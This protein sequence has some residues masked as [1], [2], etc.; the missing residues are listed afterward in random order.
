MR[1]LRWTAAALAAALA[2][3]GC[4]GLSKRKLA[5]TEPALSSAPGEPDAVAVDRPRSASSAAFIDRHPLFTKPRQYYNNTNSNKAVKTAAATV[6]GV[7]AGII[8]E[9]KQMIAGAPAPP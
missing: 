8:G 3:S 5:A 1:G 7:P 2:A 4:G 9:F 6:V